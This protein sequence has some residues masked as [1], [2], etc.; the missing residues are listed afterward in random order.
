MTTPHQ[1]RRDFAKLGLAALGGPALLGWP[2]G[3]R[4]AEPA[5]DYRFDRT[6]SREVL[7][8]HLDRAITMEGL[9]HGRGDLDDNVRMLKHIG[10]KFLGRS[11]C[12][13]AG[14]AN[15]LENLE[16]VKR[17]AAKVREADPDMVVQACIFEIVTTQ[18][19]RVPVPDWVFRALGMPVEDRS[20]RYADMLYPSGKFRDHWHKGASV[21][22]VSRPETQ[23]WFHF[24]AAS[25]I[26]AG[27]EAIHFGQM[28]LMNH[29]DR[30][31]A[32]Y[33]AVLDRA[34]DHAAQHARRRMVLCDAHV[35]G[36]GLIR[37]GKL[38]LDFHSFPLRIKEVPGQ[39]IKGVLEKGHYDSFYGRSRG[40]KTFS[41]WECEHLPYLVEID[42]W[43]AS[44]QP[45]E[46]NLGGAWVWG[47]DEMSWFAHLS[48]QERNDWLRYA[49]KWVRETDP[50][51]HLQMPGSRVLH[52]PAGGKHWY[53]ANTPYPATPGG[54][55]QEETILAIWEGDLAEAARQR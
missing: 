39:P 17:D 47:Y 31:L 10:A 29:N 41:G 28:E 35:P 44:E 5:R 51:G 20:F 1:T 22:D 53:H 11:I 46:P 40:G 4:A 33:S 27:A 3:A 32:H 21:P 16:R 50:N 9:L 2:R 24:L 38:L 54:F 36:G 8:N 55:A 18:V 19:E 12:L 49:W 14:E 52:T 42:N 25:Y 45:G 7:E 26:D 30:D 23:L 34:R 43:G 6:I 13:W 48:E 15:L 37:D